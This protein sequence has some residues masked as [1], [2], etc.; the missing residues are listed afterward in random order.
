MTAPALDLFEH[1]ERKATETALRDLLEHPRHQVTPKDRKW[2]K[3]RLRE[4]L[5]GE[6]YFERGN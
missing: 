4:H 3:A 1:A 6:N 2:L 5:D